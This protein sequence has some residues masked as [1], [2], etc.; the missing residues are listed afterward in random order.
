[1]KK[2]AIAQ[3]ALGVSV[4]GYLL[5]WASR[6]SAGY[7]IHEGLVPGSDIV[8]HCMALIKPNPLVT[9]WSLVFLALGL[10]VTGCGMLQYFEARR[11]TAG[12]ENE[13]DDGVVEP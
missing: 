6:I 1:M 8:L 10:A 13:R 12:K 7:Q 9:A 11:Q 4:V 2:L 3:I 5:F